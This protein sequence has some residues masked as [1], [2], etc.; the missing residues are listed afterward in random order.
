M[1]CTAASCSAVGWYHF[2]Y[3]PTVT[4]PENKPL[5]P[6]GDPDRHQNLIICSLAHYQP[7]LKMSCKRVRKFLRKVANR[8]TNNVENITS[9]T[10]VKKYRVYCTVEFPI[11]TWRK[12][13]VVY[14]KKTRSKCLVIVVTDDCWAVIYRRHFLNRHQRLET[15]SSK[16]ARQ[17]MLLLLAHVDLR[18][19]KNQQIDKNEWR[20]RQYS[21]PCTAAARISINK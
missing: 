18:Q 4:N 17:Q 21:T 13:S 16:N 12:M 20:W 5:Y 3:L 10:K 8:Q 19:H 15:R 9:L 7:S 11:V 2:P 6:D 1:P 14:G